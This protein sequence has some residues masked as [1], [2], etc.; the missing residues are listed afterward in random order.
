[1]RQITVHP[2][3][4]ALGGTLCL[5]LVAVPPLLDFRLEPYWL[6]LA[7]R[8]VAFG[9]TLLSGITALNSN[10]GVVAMKLDELKS[11][12]GMLTHISRQES[13]PVPTVFGTSALLVSILIFLSLLPFQTQEWHLVLI[14]ASSL[15]SGLAIAILVAARKM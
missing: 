10:L 5:W 11:D 4:L 6:N 14:I 15:I 12:D 1:M 2:F 3:Y 7:L 8:I 9:L 13:R